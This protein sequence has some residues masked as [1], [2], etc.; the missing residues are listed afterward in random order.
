MLQ[1]CTVSREMNA[2]LQSDP[3]S[4]RAAADARL[5]KLKRWLAQDPANARL[6]RDCLDTARAAG[7]YTYIK[8]L[9]EERLAA[10]PGDSE[11]LFDRATAL[12]GLRDFQGAIAILRG[13]DTSI[14]GV[15]FNLGLCHTLLGQYAE[16]RPLLAA[17]YEAGERSADSLLLYLQ[18]LHHLGEYEAAAE[19]VN[20]NEVEFR[21]S[22]ALAG[23]AAML[24]V[25]HGDKAAAGR[26]IKTALDLDPDNV[27]G[28]VAQGILLSEAFDVPAAIPVFER[29]LARAPET[30]RAWL[31]LGSMVLLAQDLP[32]AADHFAR[33]IQLM[34]THLGS[35]HLFAWTHLVGGNIDEAERAFQQAMQID[36]T[37]SETHGGLAVIAAIRRD[38]AAAERGIEIAERLDSNCNSSQ[39][40]RAVLAGNEGGPEAFRQALLDGAS[41]LPHQHRVV[42]ILTAARRAPKSSTH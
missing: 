14:P 5:A 4:T 24:F 32:R 12:I 41:A 25:D 16:S 6:R 10:A 22:A 18:S 37:F 33:A 2:Q 23:H 1:S 34:P 42:E 15:R 20:S 27:G 11:A 9:A 36:R 30:G 17:G 40:A 7:D 29:A 35:W 13:L 28:L 39:Y 38:R 8:E 19:V 21:S 3:Q 31:G 26:W